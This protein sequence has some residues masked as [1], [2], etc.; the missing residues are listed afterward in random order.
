VT[1]LISRCPQPVSAGP[2][3]SAIYLDQDSRYGSYY[4]G[5]ADSN[6]DA[7]SMAA[8]AARDAGVPVD[9]IHFSTEVSSV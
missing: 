6:S 5:R 7:A 4:V 8:R 9:A 2:D 1:R 3:T